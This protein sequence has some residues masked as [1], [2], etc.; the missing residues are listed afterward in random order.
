MVVVDE[1][2]PHATFFPADAHGLRDV[3]KF[4]VTLVAK[5]PNAITQAHGQ[6]RMAIIVEIT[7][8]AAKA[9]ASSLNSGFLRHIAESSVAEI[10]QQAAAAVRRAAHEKKI[11]FTIA[12]VVEKASTGARPRKTVRGALGLRHKR[13]WLR[14]EVHWNCGRHFDNRAERQ[15]RER[16]APLIAITRAERRS[17]MLC[18]DFLEARQMLACRSG[19]T[20]PLQSARQAKFR[21]SVVGIKSQT[22]LKCS[23]GF[24]IF[25]KLSVQVAEEI[26]GIGFLCD[27][28]D[29]LESGYAFFRLTEVFLG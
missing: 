25:L 13:I 28:R 12:V 27:F 4:A 11:G 9:T 7:G 26:V 8:R 20:L 21:R 3:L 22:F 1:R 29:V 14:R 6:I 23:D 17:E 24:V 10:V 19:I 18:R 15:F 2:H 16:V 5:E